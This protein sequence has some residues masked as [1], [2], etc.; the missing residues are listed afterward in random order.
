[1]REVGEKSLMGVTHMNLREE[2]AF[3]LGRDPVSW[4]PWKYLEEMIRRW[5]WVRTVAAHMY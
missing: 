2:S 5:D 3:Q 4:L 1:M